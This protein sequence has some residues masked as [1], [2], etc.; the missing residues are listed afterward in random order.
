MRYQY[1]RPRT[2][3]TRFSEQAEAALREIFERVDWV[4]RVM[5]ECSCA[6]GTPASASVGRSRLIGGFTWPT[7]RSLDVRYEAVRV[8]AP[9]LAAFWDGN[10]IRSQRGRYQRPRAYLGQTSGGWLQWARA[11]N[12]PRLEPSRAGPSIGLADRAYS[13]PRCGSRSPTTAVRCYHLRSPG[14]R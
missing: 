11:A 7:P 1:T 8:P 4:S 9:P 5:G 13:R 14:W 12:M 6:C 3:P 2:T 10:P